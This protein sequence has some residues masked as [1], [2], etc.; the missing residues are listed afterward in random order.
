MD[1]NELFARVA[2]RLKLADE[3][4]IARAKETISKRGANTIAEALVVNGSITQADAEKIRNEGHS[5]SQTDAPV[6]D[7]YEILDKIGQGGMGVVWKARQLSLNRMVAIKILPATL[8]SNTRLVER[9]RREALSTAKLNHPNIVSA[10]DVGKI[11]RPG[12]PDQ[13]YFVMEFIDGE[14]LDEVLARA[15]QIEPRRA[16][17][18]AVAVAAA[19]D[20]AWAQASMVHRDIKPANILITRAGQVKLADMGLAKSAWET[21]RLT[22]AGLAIGTPQYLSPE[23]ARGLEDIDTRSDIYSLGATLF[24]MLTGKPMHGDGPPDVLIARHLNKNAPLCC[25]LNPALPPGISAIVARMTRRDPAERYQTPGELLADLKRFLAG[26]RPL[27]YTT[28]LQFRQRDT[29]SNVR[30]AQALPQSQTAGIAAPATPRNRFP[31]IPLIVMIIAI[32]VGGAWYAQ[33]T[34]RIDIIR[35][36]SPP[37]IAGET[38]PNTTTP[39]AINASQLEL[40]FNLS[41]PDSVV[42]AGGTFPLNFGAGSGFRVNLRSDRSGFVHVIMLVGDESG[43]IRARLVAPLAEPIPIRANVLKS[44]P[45]KGLFA[46]DPG[47]KSVAV[48]AVVSQRPRE[49]ETFASALAEL[50][51]K[52]VGPIRL[53]SGTYWR[54]GAD[55]WVDGDGAAPDAHTAGILDTIAAGVFGTFGDEA[56]SGTAASAVW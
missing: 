18:I 2:L 11:Q 45:V 51:R 8:S 29:R 28:I 53:V 10:I 49:R 38:A 33:K 42:G 32:A 3:E 17:E 26:E 56:V 47:A 40:W 6:I 21:S 15:G 23:Q 22:S 54:M 25:E 16:T 50:N 37:K 44:L 34:G 5:D 27:A 55:K 43:S 30:R 52:L 48:F 41:N 1:E 12:A 35:Q 14:S 19:L 9:F 31:I 24:Q 36:A 13:H 4:Q 39:P 20:H 46:V 7:G